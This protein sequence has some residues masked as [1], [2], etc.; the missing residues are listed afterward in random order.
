MCQANWTRAH[1]CCHGATSSQKSGLFISKWFRKYGRSLARPRRPHS[2]SF[3]T[4]KSLLYMHGSFLLEWMWTLTGGTGTEQSSAVARPTYQW[5]TCVLSGQVWPLWDQPAASRA[6]TTTSVL[7]PHSMAWLSWFPICVVN[8]IHNTSEVSKGNVHGY[9]CNFG[10]LR[11]GNEY[12]VPC[13]AMAL[14]ESVGTSGNVN[15]RILCR[16]IARRL[17][18]SGEIWR[19]PLPSHCFIFTALHE[20]MVVQ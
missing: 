11:Y 7:P 8:K 6:S 17:A 12:C 1:T 9:Y 13:C 20:P 15:L 14:Y 3:I 10:S 4:R 19:A 18:H 2:L 5:L 16:N